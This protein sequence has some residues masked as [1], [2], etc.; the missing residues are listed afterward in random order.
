MKS[1]RARILVLFIAVIAVSVIAIGYPRLRLEYKLWSVSEDIQS[2]LAMER[3][4]WPGQLDIEDIQGG[5]I[6]YLVHRTSSEK[7]LITQS[8]YEKDGKCVFE[9]LWSDIQSDF[10]QLAY[11]SDYGLVPYSGRL[12][13]WNPSNHIVGTNL[14]A[15]SAETVESILENKRPAP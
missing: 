8:P 7:A 15:L 14:Q 12:H 1:T 11:C 4:S 3:P 9:F 10:I 2:G 13:G 5:S 6:V